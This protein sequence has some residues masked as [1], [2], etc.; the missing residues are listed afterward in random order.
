[1]NALLIFAA[2]LRHCEDNTA[3]GHTLNAQRGNV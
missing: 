1:M 2:M 3:Q